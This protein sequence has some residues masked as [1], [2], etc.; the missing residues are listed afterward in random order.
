[1]TYGDEQRGR[2]IAPEY[3]LAITRAEAEIGTVRTVRFH[4][5]DGRERSVAVAVPPGATTGMRL[6]VQI[7]A[8][9]DGFGLSYGALV[10]VL[11]V[12]PHVSSECRGSDV[13]VALQAD[14]ASAER[15]GEVRVTLEDG[16]VLVVP[17][18]PGVTYDR[19]VYFGQGLARGSAPL[20]RGDLILHLEL[21][22]VE[23]P[24]DRPAPEPIEAPRVW[25]RALL[26]I[27]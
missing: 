8:Q 15:D 9:P 27:E 20:R 19:F 3:R 12:L 14:R 25:W 1:M 16:R 23:A 24:A 18:R 6:P 2:T 10:V 5:A 11:T 26:R 22:D 21:V 7:P 13:Y 4:G 17:V